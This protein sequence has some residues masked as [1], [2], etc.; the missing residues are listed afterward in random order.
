[1]FLTRAQQPFSP[2]R[3][4]FAGFAVL[5]AV[6]TFPRSYVCI[7]VSYEYLLGRPSK[8]PHRVMIHLWTYSNLWKD[9]S[10]DSTV[11]KI[12]V[13]PWAPGQS[14]HTFHSTVRASARFRS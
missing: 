12:E 7:F 3:A 8:T 6:H 13:G 2:T 11:A 5:L 4:I 14:Y 1:M 10:T 9:S